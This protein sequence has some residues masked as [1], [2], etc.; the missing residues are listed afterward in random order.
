MYQLNLSKEEYELMEELVCHAYN[1][2]VTKS[3]IVEIGNMLKTV[4]TIPIPDEL[5]AEMD[6]AI[7][8]FSIKFDLIT[9]IHDR[10]HDLQPITIVPKAVNNLKEAEVNNRIINLSSDDERM[11]TVVFSMLSTYAE[12]VPSTSPNY[13]VGDKLSAIKKAQDFIWR[14]ITSIK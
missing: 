7:D 8:D 6:E 1:Q 3:K 2:S 5:K 4:S 13:I 14:L 11:L 10:I 9:A 12:I